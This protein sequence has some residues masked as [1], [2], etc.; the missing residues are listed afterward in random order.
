MLAQEGSLSEYCS[1]LRR[2][3]SPFDKLK[4][5][6]RQAMNAEFTLLLFSFE[7]KENNNHTPYSNIIILCEYMH[8]ITLL[9]LLRITRT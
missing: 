2:P 7:R 1:P 6:P 3:T 9:C 8:L 5:M 4:A